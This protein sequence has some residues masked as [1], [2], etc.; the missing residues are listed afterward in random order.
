MYKSIVVEDR[1]KLV[2][3]VDTLIFSYENNKGGKIDFFSLTC[4][5]KEYNV[6]LVIVF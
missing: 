5:T 1:F 6:K 2:K 3:Q 4:S